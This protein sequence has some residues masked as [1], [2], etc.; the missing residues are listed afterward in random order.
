MT[1]GK[2]IFWLGIHVL[3]ERGAVM[4]LVLYWFSKAVSLVNIK[5]T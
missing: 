3:Q 5:M 2:S 4:G 1:G